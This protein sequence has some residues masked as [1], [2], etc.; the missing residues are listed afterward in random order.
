MS[1]IM[2][3][4]MIDTPDPLPALRRL[5]ITAAIGWQDDEGTLV[6]VTADHANLRRLENFLRPAP[7]LLEAA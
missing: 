4:V 6:F 5:G 2:L 7:T 3:P 1:S